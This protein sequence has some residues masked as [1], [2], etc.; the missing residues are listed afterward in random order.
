VILKLFFCCFEASN[1]P[2]A[3]EIR[4]CF[5]HRIISFEAKISPWCNQT[6]LGF[7]GLY[8]H[9]QVKHRDFPAI[10]VWL[11]VTSVWIRDFMIVFHS[12]IAA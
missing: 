10:H 7:K 6:W 5:S 2:V 1:P 9:H 12:R 11:K 4:A 3:H 8:K